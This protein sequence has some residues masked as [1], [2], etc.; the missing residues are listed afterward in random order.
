MATAFLSW[1]V[2]ERAGGRVL[3]VSEKDLSVLRPIPHSGTYR[4]SLPAS[5][6]EPQLAIVL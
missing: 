4:W 1:G 3:A 5:E 2:F 6:D